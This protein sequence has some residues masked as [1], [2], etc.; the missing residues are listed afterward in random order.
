M[1]PPR[2]GEHLN[3]MWLGSP[4][5]RAWWSVRR[6]AAAWVWLP[7]FRPPVR[8]MISL[9]VLITTA[10]RGRLL[11]RYTRAVRRPL[12]PPLV[13]GLLPGSAGSE[14][15]SVLSHDFGSGQRY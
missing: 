5:R 3:I 11:D 7:S 8:V 12:L 4:P 2:G 10:G 13:R 15:G 9:L 14:V 1:C 6:G